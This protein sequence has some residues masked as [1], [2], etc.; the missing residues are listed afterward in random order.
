MYSYQS[1]I[2]PEYTARRNC[3]AVACYSAAD[4]LIQF[5]GRVDL[6][7]PVCYRMTKS[8]VTAAVFKL[9]ARFLDT[10]KSDVAE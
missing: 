7:S 1:L 6:F 9:E 10:F 4:P 2:V 8:H 3:A 5:S